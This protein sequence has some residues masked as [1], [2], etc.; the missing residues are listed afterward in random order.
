MDNVLKKYINC[1]QNLKEN[2]IDV[3]LECVSEDIIFIDPFNKITGKDAVEEMFKKMFKKTKKPNFKV[4]YAI[5]D[6]EIKLIKW[7][8]SCIIF[9]KTIEFS[10]L[11]EIKIKKNVII[12]HEDFWDSGRNLYCN[13]P[14]LGKIF[15]KI[16]K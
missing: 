11:S 8:F 2:N 10:G 1:F 15:K 7:N 5:G 6:H 13:I 3:L 12:Q 14:L 16:H 9:G 4:L